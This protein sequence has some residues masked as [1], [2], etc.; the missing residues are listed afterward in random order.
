MKVLKSKKLYALIFMVIVMSCLGLAACKPKEEPLTLGVLAD[1][2]S[3]PFVLAKNLGYLDGTSINIVPFTS[4]VD[5]DSAMQSGNIDGA[6]SDMAA[7]AMAQNGGFDYYIAGTSNGIYGIVA[8][9]A[10]GIT[11]VAGLSG[12]QIGLSTH[13]IIEYVTDSILEENAVTDVEKVPIPSMPSRLEFL[14][15]NQ[16]DA[17]AVP[18]PF[19][20]IASENGTKIMTS[21]DIGLAAGVLV[22][23]GDAID[24][25][26]GEISDLFAAYNRALDYIANAEDNSYL[27]DIV[28][29]LALPEALLTMPTPVYPTIGEPDAVQIDKVMAWLLKNEMIDKTYTYD[30]LVRLVK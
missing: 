29:E 8:S 1:I 19:I 12:K 15:N 14:A 11:D 26:S 3:I 21:D 24:N 25:K 10:S 22:F 2:N 28:T 4:P 17:I 20:T 27:N 9:E 5:R 7:V 18:E 23:T 30:D 6:I 13:T 16:I